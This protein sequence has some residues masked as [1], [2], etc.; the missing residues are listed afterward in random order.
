MRYCLDPVIGDTHTGPYVEPGLERVFAERLLPHA[1]LVTPNA[2]ELG[3]LTGLPSLEQDDAI[4][5][6]RA[7]LARGPQWVLAHSVA[8]GTGELVTLAVSAEAVYRWA[9]P[10]LPVDVAGT[11]DVLMA[12]LI[13]LLLRDVPFEQ[14]VGH[15]LTGVHAALEAT[16]A[17]GFE[18]FDVLAAAPAAL[19]TAP[20]FAVERLA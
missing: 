19:G 14:A 8:G 11:G 7:L 3:R 9:S 20:R 1:W 4:V 5:A 2:F 12:L 18:E 6:A 16:L 10:H 17:A 13:G 15:A